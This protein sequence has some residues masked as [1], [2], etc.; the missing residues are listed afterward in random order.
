MKKQHGHHGHQGHQ[1]HRNYDRDYHS[2]NLHKFN[3]MYQ[4]AS[5]GQAAFT[6]FSYEIPQGSRCYFG[7]C[8]TFVEVLFVQT[9]ETKG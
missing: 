1:G 2:S 6:Q 5:F 8:C 7:L 3:A 9:K 4:K